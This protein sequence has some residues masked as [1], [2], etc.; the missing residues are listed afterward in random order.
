[1]N[2][3][4]V[5]GAPVAGRFCTLV[6]YVFLQCL[7]VRG[8]P[9]CSEMGVTRTF[10]CVLSVKMALVPSKPHLAPPRQ[11]ISKMTQKTFFPR[12]VRGPLGCHLL[13]SLVP[14]SRFRGSGIFFFR[15]A[16]CHLK[17]CRITPWV[18]SM[19]RFGLNPYLELIS[20]FFKKSY[21]RY[22]LAFLC[23]SGPNFKLFYQESCMLM[24]FWIL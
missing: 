7:S 17:W 10:A 18:C 24:P 21:F 11:P 23:P 13:S 12:I 3:R 16:R 5:E 19:P 6:L 8:S 22:F 20:Q 9:L 15:N 2:K 1:M 14:K 4:P